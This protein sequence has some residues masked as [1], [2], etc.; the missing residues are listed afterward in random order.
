MSL[1]RPAPRRRWSVP[2]GRCPQAGGLILP[3][4]KERNHTAPAMLYR[5]AGLLHQP[6]ELRKVGKTYPQS[7]LLQSCFTGLH[8]EI[9]GL[10]EIGWGSASAVLGFIRVFPV[11]QTILQRAGDGFPLAD[12]VGNGR[13][14]NTLF[15]LLLIRIKNISTITF[16]TI[17]FHWTPPLRKR[18]SP[19]WDTLSRSRENRGA[20]HATPRKG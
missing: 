10:L 6:Q 19:P 7:H 20:A 9:P 11:V 14:G 3:G 1:W 18:L 13:R 17:L 5:K 4:G 2:K 15:S 8:P 16:I 12:M